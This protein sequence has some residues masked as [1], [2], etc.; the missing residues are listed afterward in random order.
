MTE[1]QFTIRIEDD[2]S[3]ER[4][5][6]QPGGPDEP[7]ILDRLQDIPEPPPVVSMTGDDV[8]EA[9]KEIVVI[10][11]EEGR[12]TETAAE[13][14][15]RGVYAPGEFDVQGAARD[16]LPDVE[17]G[18][19]FSAL[20]EQFLE[21][22]Q[23]IIESAGSPIESTEITMR[24]MSQVFDLVAEEESRRMDEFEREYNIKQ[25]ARVREQLQ[26]EEDRAERRAVADE[27]RAISIET[28]EN[29]R[30]ANREARDQRRVMDRQIRD[31]EKMETYER[32]YNLR[33]KNR[34]VEM[35]DRKQR[36]AREARRAKGQELS[37]V[38]RYISHAVSGFVGKHTRSGILGTV[39]GTASENLIGMFANRK[40]MRRG[41]AMARLASRRLAK[42]S[43]S[44]GRGVL[45]KLPVV[46]R[47]ASSAMGVA[48]GAGSAVTG[49]VAAGGASL[50][51]VAGPLAA[52]AAIMAVGAKQGAEAFG[53]LGTA[54]GAVN[55]EFAILA[56]ATRK[57]VSTFGEG[58]EEMARYNAEAAV[59]TATMA[60]EN[61]MSALR[62]ANRLGP[63]TSEYA[64]AGHEWSA[65][66]SSLDTE[67]RYMA[68]NFFRDIIPISE[69]IV[70]YLKSITKGVEAVNGF[71][72]KYGISFLDFMGSTGSGVKAVIKLYEL[73]KDDKIRKEADEFTR[74]LREDPLFGLH[75]WAPELPP[76]FVPLAAPAVP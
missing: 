19:H 55:P 10:D 62:R 68:A 40:T 15:D 11:R 71:A 24:H 26:R 50:A 9:A 17:L 21:N 34:Q 39:S 41:R 7:R 61:E 13:P 8:A 5:A 69:I 27:D 63:I 66:V 60:I 44:A 47:A 4:F 59:A 22:L 25:D 12:S 70:G 32:E 46:G 54:V 37:G 76:A 2:G 18:E 48:A 14:P 3:A 42:V 45:S 35:E 49:A 72:D 56:S 1:G 30:Q 52:S 65:A 51:A 43:E 73:M 29:L 58:V 53:T 16:V 67:L 57:L 20:K 36:A 64:T 74:Q 23:S 33:E 6:P 75:G 38:G 31:E 28:E